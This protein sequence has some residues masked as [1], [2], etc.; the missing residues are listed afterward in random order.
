MI[1]ASPSPS[2]TS[3]TRHNTSPFTSVRSA[4]ASRGL[5]SSY[6]RN[7][8][9]GATTRNF[10][11]LVSIGRRTLD[12]PLPLVM[13]S[14]PAPYQLGITSQGDDAKS[15]ARQHLAEGG[16]IEGALRHELRLAAVPAH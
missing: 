2:A 14:S 6:C 4:H 1:S 7:G 3:C 12:L 13:P 9:A 5:P 11:R 10:R 8:S 16:R 15:S